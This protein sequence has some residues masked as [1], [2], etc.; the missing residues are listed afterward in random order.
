MRRAVWP[1][2]FGKLFS[3]YYNYFLAIL[4]NK[5]YYLQNVSP[6]LGV[7]SLSAR[8]ASPLPFKTA[9]PFG[10]PIAFPKCEDLNVEL[11]SAQ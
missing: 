8:K 7:R 3:I 2:H 1:V 11:S 5:A 9:L 6:A 10:I 4:G